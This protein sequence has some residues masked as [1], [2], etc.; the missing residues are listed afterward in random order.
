MKMKFP[1][2]ATFIHYKLLIFRLAHRVYYATCAMLPHYS[3]NK[4]S[5]MV[6]IGC[7]GKI[8]HQYTSSYSASPNVSTTTYGQLSP[9]ALPKVQVWDLS[10][11]KIKEMTEDMYK[12][13]EV[14]N[15]TD[16]WPSVSVSDVTSTSY[17]ESHTSSVDGT[18]DQPN[19]EN[20][21]FKEL[22]D[23]HLVYTNAQGSSNGEV[24]FFTMVS[25]STS[26]LLIT[27][28]LLMFCS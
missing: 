18:D 10:S 1:N 4:Y 5:N 22:D 16:M 2:N 21:K 12:C 26:Y 6:V 25:L 7:G 19:N 8:Q 23:T 13:P 17:N 20:G 24:H 27:H 3:L 14:D 15:D 28:T 9:S 11:N